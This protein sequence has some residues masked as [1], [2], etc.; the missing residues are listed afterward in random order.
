MHPL[1][2]HNL[3]PLS[4]CCAACL[5]A[6]NAWRLYNT[7]HADLAEQTFELQLRGRWVGWGGHEEVAWHGPLYFCV[8]DALPSL[9]A[10]EGLARQH[11]G[12]A[13]LPADGGWAWG[14]QQQ[15]VAEMAA[16]AAGGRLLPLLSGLPSSGSALQS[17]SS[18]QMAACGPS[19]RWSPLVSECRGSLAS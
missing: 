6:D 10:T 4:C 19:A 11:T 5:P 17:T 9:V 13:T 2:D 12:I 15:L 3:S 7:Q 16:P 8:G 18:Q 14:Q 1:L